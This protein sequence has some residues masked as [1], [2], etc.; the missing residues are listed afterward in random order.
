VLLHI[1]QWYRFQEKSNDPKIQNLDRVKYVVWHLFSIFSFKRSVMWLFLIRIRS[2]LHDSHSILLLS[3]LPSCILPSSSNAAFTL[4]GF[5]DQERNLT[6][7]KTAFQVS[8]IEAFL[9][10]PGCQTCMYKRGISLSLFL[11][12]LTAAALF[13]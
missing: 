8:F 2:V 5:D 4:S 11:S 10:V 13:S 3:Y 1:C 6:F 7:V 12:Q 9:S